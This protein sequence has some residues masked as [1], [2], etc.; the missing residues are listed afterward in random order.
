VAI[1]ARLGKKLYKG[2]AY[3][4]AFQ[5]CADQSKVKLYY[6]GH[7]TSLAEFHEMQVRFP[8]IDHWMIG[9]G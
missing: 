4:D 6:N 2:G 7:I 3:L 5:T 8:T 1:Q 9:R